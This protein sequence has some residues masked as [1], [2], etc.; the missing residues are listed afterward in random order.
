MANMRAK[1][2]Y[3]CLGKIDFIFETN[4]W[5][6]YRSESGDKV[7]PFDKKKPKVENSRAST[8]CDWNQMRRAK[9]LQ[10]G[11]R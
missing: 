1:F 4:L 9:Y 3:E 5:Y 7:I 2:D 8:R 6:R 11:S 10:Y